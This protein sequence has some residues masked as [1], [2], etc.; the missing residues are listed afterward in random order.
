MAAAGR[1]IASKTRRQIDRDS[2]MGRQY[3]GGG[4]SAYRGSYVSGPYRASAPG[5]PPV[6][7]S[8]TLHGSIRSYAFPDGGGFAVRA[9]TFYA[10]FLEA[11]A[12]GGGNPGTGRRN[13][14]MRSRG[15][16]AR[17]QFTARQL[18]PRPFLNRVMADSAESLQRRMRRAF[19]SGA[20]WRETK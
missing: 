7:V 3:Y 6:N 10:L 14:R 12:S 2:G 1:E 11:G 18:D 9:R 17:G 5:E 20:K 4:G 13:P 16:R 19:E 8:G 15:R